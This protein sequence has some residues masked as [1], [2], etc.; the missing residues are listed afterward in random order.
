MT[1]VPVGTRTAGWR[2]NTG[3]V[4]IRVVALAIAP[5]LTVDSPPRMWAITGRGEWLDC[6]G[7]P[8]DGTVEL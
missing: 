4:L 3:D 5:S 2:K 1:I 7:R 6:G 8:S